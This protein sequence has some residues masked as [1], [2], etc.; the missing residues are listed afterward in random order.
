MENKTIAKLIERFR[1][2]R[3]AAEER[4]LINRERALIR[5]NMKEWS[6]ADKAEGILKLIWINMLGY[7]TEFSQV[8]TMNAL[9]NDNFKIKTIGY[10]GLTLFLSETSEVLMMATNRIRR[11]LEHP[12]NDFLVALALKAFSEIADSNMV[13]DLFQNIKALLDS[14]S[15]YVKKKAMLAL[16][17]VISKKPEYAEE[18][19][20]HLVLDLR[21]QNQGLLLATLHL[22]HAIIKVRPGLRSHFYG[23]LDA[24]YSTLRVLQSRFGTNYSINGVNDPFLHCAIIAFVR[25]V[26]HDN[27]THSDDFGSCV[28]GLCSNL[29]HNTSSTSRA[30]LY[31]CA[32]AI[33]SLPSSLALKKEGISILGNFLG[34]K[35]KNYLYV[36]LV[37]LSYASNQFKEEVA[38]YD[39]ILQKCVRGKDFTIKKLALQVLQ[40]VLNQA[41]AGE[42]L[43]LILNEFSQE[44]NPRELRE[45]SEIAFSIVEQKSPNALWFLNQVVTVLQAIKSE[46][47]IESIDNFLNVFSHHEKLQT[48][49]IFRVLLAFRDPAIFDSESFV[50]SAFWLFG[51]FLELFGAGRDAVGA[52]VPTVKIS[53]ILELIEAAPIDRYSYST[54]ASLLF[55]ITKIHVKSKTAEDKKKSLDLI[56]KFKTLKQIHT[57]RKASELLKILSLKNVNIPELFEAIPPPNLNPLLS[58]LADTNVEYGRLEA[59]VAEF[60]EGQVVSSIQKDDFAD[61]IGFDFEPIAQT[62]QTTHQ[63]PSANEDLNMLELDPKPVTSA[64][65]DRKKS[66]LDL[67]ELSGPDRSQ[68]VLFDTKPVKTDHTFGSNNHDNFD[69]LSSG[70]VPQTNQKSQTTQDADFLDINVPKKSNY[71]GLDVVDWALGGSKSSD[72][73]HHSNHSLLETHN[74]PNNFNLSVSE[75]TCSSKT[76][77]LIFSQQN[78]NQILTALKI[79]V[80]NISNDDIEDLNIECKAPVGI[81][82]LSTFTNKKSIS[83]L[84][85]GE[86]KTDLVIENQNQHSEGLFS[87]KINFQVGLMPE[88][89]EVQK[90]IKFG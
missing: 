84:S 49:I 13:V 60:N 26:V 16:L 34:L 88:I 63:T 75:N 45:L 22:C 47:K 23:S 24:L 21:E 38:K 65:A 29:H 6:I 32:Q 50:K 51:E 72:Q 55:C 76:I 31:Q 28:I 58:T 9:F 59:E 79:E 74:I 89:V 2:C 7:E 71:D 78:M 81:K 8:E 80:N 33:M 10:L 48:T 44:K 19:I 40:N 36:S 61:L 85:K 41:N 86:S 35:N 90:L 56:K 67:L 69:F 46:V 54:N 12:S 30:V 27:K 18:L 25:D 73:A 83:S 66:D 11:D 53:K 39:K 57:F 70:Q 62:N 77:E 17:R 5:N 68:E 82:I 42:V 87:F 14:D 15:K 1:E 37:M 3:T 20:P 43:K 52:K 4:E 64:P